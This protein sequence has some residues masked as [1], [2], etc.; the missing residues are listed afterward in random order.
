LPTKFISRAKGK[1]AS[2]HESICRHCKIVLLGA[3]PAPAEDSTCPDPNTSIRP[4]A[5]LTPREALPQGVCDKKQICETPGYCQ[6][7]YVRGELKQKVFDLYHIPHDPAHYQVDHLVSVCL[8]GSTTIKNLW[9]QLQSNCVS[10]C[11]AKTKDYLEGL[12]HRLVCSGEV[13]LAT[14]QHDIATNWVTAYQKYVGKSCE[15]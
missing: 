2:D 5:K 14:A 15:R 10:K 8:C 3:S 9:P 11:N 6:R 7:R 12:L 13:D 4:D 1:P